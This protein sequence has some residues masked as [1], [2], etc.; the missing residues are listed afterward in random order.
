[1]GPVMIQKSLRLVIKILA[2]REHIVFVVAPVV[3][4]PLWVVANAGLFEGGIRYA[5]ERTVFPL[6]VPLGSAHYSE[7]E[8]MPAVEFARKRGK[9]RVCTEQRT[10]CIPVAAGMRSHGRECPPFFGKPRGIRHAVLLIAVVSE[11]Q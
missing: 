6:E 5:V 9:V 4:T 8:R 7:M 3:I 1:D 2:P 11:R 10:V